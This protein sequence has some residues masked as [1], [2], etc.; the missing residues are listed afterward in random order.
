MP[1]GAIGSSWA[2]GSWE[3]TAWEAGSWADLGSVQTP[4]VFG[5]L[6]TLVVNDLETQYA[7]AAEDYNTILVGRVTDY[8]EG[9]NALEADVNT[10]AA[11]FLS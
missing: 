7:S 3:D 2:A 11:I 4:A 6:T 9:A 10:D 1:A 8:R 5:D